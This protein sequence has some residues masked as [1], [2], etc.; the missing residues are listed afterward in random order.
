MIKKVL[1]KKLS[2]TLEKLPFS[3]HYAAQ[4]QKLLRPFYLSLACKFESKLPISIENGGVVLTFDDNFIDEWYYADSLLRKYNWKA[5]F[6]VSFIKSLSYQQFDKLINLQ[7]RG[8]EIGGHGFNHFNQCDF[9]SSCGIKEYINDEIIPLI[10][11]MRQRSIK[12]DSFAYPFGSR[13]ERLDY[14]LLDYFKILRATSYD[15]VEPNEHNCYFKKRRLIFG[16]GIDN[17]YEHFSEDYIVKLL[18]YAKKTKQILIL[19]GHKPVDNPFSKYETKIATL[20]N[21][22]DFINKNDMK[23]YTASELFNYISLN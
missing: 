9:V 2:K 8:H 6:F 16:L 4:Q 10:E 22:C 19:Y 12:I 15:K 13:D 23:F 20:E 3:F 18:S 21:I 17:N 7:N 5:T 1:V 14:F 11:S